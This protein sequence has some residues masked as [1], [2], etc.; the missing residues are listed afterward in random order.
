[1][2][3]K[4]NEKLKLVKGALIF[5]AGASFLAWTIYDVFFK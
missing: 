5:V 2:E 1:M 4:M 3:N